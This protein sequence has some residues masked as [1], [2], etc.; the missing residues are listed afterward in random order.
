MENVM[1]EPKF[2]SK[3]R[4]SNVKFM[5][6][7]LVIVAAIGFLAVSSFQA[8]SMYYLTVPE[9]KQQANADG[10]GFF[11]KMVRVSGPLHKE[12]IDWNAKTMTLKFHINEADEMFPVV[13]VGVIPDTMENGESV[14]VEGKYTPEGI[15]NASTIL[16]KCPSKYEP[17]TGD[18]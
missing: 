2:V 18:M 4:K 9:L 8:N 17:E 10:A 14:V 5:V 12:S 13:Y 15:F 11:E 6:A 7:G 16:V 1:V 3:P